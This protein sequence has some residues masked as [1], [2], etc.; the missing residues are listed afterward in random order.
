MFNIFQHIRDSEGG[1]SNVTFV[2]FEVPETLVGDYCRSTAKGEYPYYAV[3]GN[4]STAWTNRYNIADQQYFIIDFVNRKIALLSYTI[5]T[6]CNP[7]KGLLLFGSNDK[8]EWTI[9]SNVTQ[10][11]NNYSAHSFKVFNHSSFRY[12]RFN[13][14][15]SI[16]DYR[17]IVRNIEFYG[18]FG[19][20][21]LTKGTCILLKF[22][23][24]YF[25]SLVML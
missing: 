4:K 23:Y 8:I 19:D 6:L 24:M 14:T 12:F 18:T 21:F 1:L 20:I 11:F 16:V 25:Y 17:F 5:E 2:N 7:P 22:P 3:D 9:L 15:E 13:Q 10:T